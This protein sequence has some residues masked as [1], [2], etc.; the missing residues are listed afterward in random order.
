MIP[1]TKRAHAMSDDMTID[2]PYVIPGTRQFRALPLRAKKPIS[3]HVYRSDAN[4]TSDDDTS[5][6]DFDTDLGTV[7]SDIEGDLD[8][9]SRDTSVEMDEDEGQQVDCS[10]PA[11]PTSWSEKGKAVDPR[12]HGGDNKKRKPVEDVD[13]DAD[14]EAEVS[15]VVTKRA[16]T[17]GPVSP[18]ASLELT[19]SL[20]DCTS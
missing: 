11:V 18:S 4:S 13:C 15:K 10:I 8:S 2:V 1:I 17:K 5:E 7:L 14:D 6:D 3:F 9:F 16:R 19:R 20:L 12:E